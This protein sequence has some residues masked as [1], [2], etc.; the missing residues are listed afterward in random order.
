[1][2]DASG[3]EPYSPEQLAAYR[4]EGTPVF[5]DFTA[6]WCLT[7]QVNKRTVLRRAEILQA[8]RD[9]GVKLMEAD[10]TDQNETI[11]K[12]LAGYGRQSVPV[13]VLYGADPE[14]SPTLLPELLTRKIVLDAL[15]NDL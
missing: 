9:R 10:W 14:A 2:S 4:A 6:K 5:I 1:S 11:A 15:Q 3:W 7:C 13:Y 12:A 8:F